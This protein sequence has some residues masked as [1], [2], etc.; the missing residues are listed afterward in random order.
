VPRIRAIGLLGVEN[1]IT[2]E[3]REY[4]HDR[5]IERLVR[6]H[7]T[8][9]IIIHLRRVAVVSREPIGNARQ[10]GLA[11]LLG[12]RTGAEHDRRQ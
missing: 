4:M 10:I 2:D 1:Q 9:E 11:K 8:L 3:W 12:V 5:H 7:D 6:V